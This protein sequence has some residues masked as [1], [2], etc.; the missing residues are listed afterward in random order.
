[1]FATITSVPFV[2]PT[3]ALF[4]STKVLLPICGSTSACFAFNVN[5]AVCAEPIVV[6]PLYVVKVKEW[7][8]DEG[9]EVLVICAK[10]EEELSYM[11]KQKIA[12]SLPPF[13]SNNIFQ[14]FPIL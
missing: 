1:M 13:P 10:T 14:K 7:A 8:K 4:V 9:S 5:V 2:I 12:G 11:K 6:L 3:I